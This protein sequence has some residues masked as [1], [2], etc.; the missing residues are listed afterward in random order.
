MTWTALLFAG[1]GWIV[2]RFECFMRINHLING[3]IIQWKAAKCF[4]VTFDPSGWIR[5]VSSCTEPCQSSALL[6][7]HANAMCYTIVY[8]WSRDHMP[9]CTEPVNIFFLIFICHWQKSAYKLL[10]DESKQLQL[11]GIS[12]SKQTADLRKLDALRVTGKVCLM[13]MFIVAVEVLIT[14]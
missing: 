7:C 5:T 8:P 2:N 11:N 13:Y 1:V 12:C 9:C 3:R 14:F 6:E 10:E 4:A